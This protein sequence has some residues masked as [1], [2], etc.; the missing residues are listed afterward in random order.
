[1]AAV[2]VTDVAAEGGDLDAAR[3]L[4]VFAVTCF[5]RRFGGGHEHDSELLAYSV[6]FGENFHHLSRSRIR[7][8]VVVLGLAI[9]QEIADAASGKIGLKAVLAQGFNDRLGEIPH[10]RPL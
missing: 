7:G 8:D 1:M 3:V 5:G 4:A 10:W 9:E 2:G 6:G